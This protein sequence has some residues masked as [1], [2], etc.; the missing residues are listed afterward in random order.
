MKSEI[1]LFITST[2]CYIFFY[3]KQFI[4]GPIYSFFNHRINL[5]LGKTYAQ[6]Y[7]CLYVF[8]ILTK[9]FNLEL[10]NFDTLFLRW[11]TRNFVYQIWKKKSFWFAVAELSCQ[12][13]MRGNYLHSNVIQYN[14]VKPKTFKPNLLDE[15]KDISSPEFFFSLSLLFL[16]RNYLWTE[17]KRPTPWDSV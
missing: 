17:V 11:L 12:G 1:V 9:P 13:N 10:S 6:Q 7:S 14:T 5:I 3:F 15:P 2:C 16:N 8:F 4:L